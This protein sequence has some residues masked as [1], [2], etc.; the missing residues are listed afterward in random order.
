MSTR[1]NKNLIIRAIFFYKYRTKNTLI[2]TNSKYKKAF[3]KD[4]K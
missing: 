4:F 3:F 1:N 2:L